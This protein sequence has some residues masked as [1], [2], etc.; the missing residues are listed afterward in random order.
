MSGQY[1]CIN[2][3]SYK[4]IMAVTAQL[5]TTNITVSMLS[6]YIRYLM[7][8]PIYGRKQTGRTTLVF[9][10]QAYNMV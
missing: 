1:Q 3:L 7:N 10:D 2:F 5:I 8:E 6:Y 9:L 4:N